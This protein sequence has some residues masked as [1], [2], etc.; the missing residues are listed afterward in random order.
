MTYVILLDMPTV[1]TYFQDEN[2]QWWVQFKRN[3]RTRAHVA[4][5]EQ[6][7]KEFVT[8]REA[9]YC[10]VA[11]RGESRAKE[12]EGRICPQ[13]QKTFAPIVK[14]QRYCSH[15]CAATSHHARQEVTT[16]ANEPIKNID[17]PL[18]SVDQNGQWWYR[19]DG[20]PRT[21]AYLKRCVVCHVM[22]LANIWHKNKQST[23]SKQCGMVLFHKNNPDQNT[24]EKSARWKGGRF[25]AGGGY[26]KCYAPHHPSVRD[27][28]KRYVF[29]H[30][31]V[32]EGLIGRFLLPHESVHH[33][34]G[35]RDDN[36][37]E[38][39]ELWAHSHPS[40]QR[41]E[42]QQ[43]CPTCTCFRKAD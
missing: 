40:G 27:K 6:C 17:N 28:G 2:G 22:F 12:V 36:R 9:R 24:A 18:F 31:L 29:E 43:H 19:P 25:H 33:K 11:C 1:N 14:R 5:C 35:V 4:E 13:C 37:P 15:S 16:K 23:C 7:K 20:H 41:V 3:R 30:R 42:E 39:L 32:M 8:W 21:R 38:N 34:N 10:S 26:V